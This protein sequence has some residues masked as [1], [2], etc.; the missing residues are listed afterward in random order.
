MQFTDQNFEAEV[1]KSDVPVL[2]DFFAEWC[3]PCLMMGPII[4]ELAEEMKDKKV[5]IGKV[6]ID[7]AP[8]AAKK[9]N[10]MS[11]PTIIIFKD[12]EPAETMSG[13]QNKET[14]REKLGK[15]I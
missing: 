9:Y 8:E 1:I 13:I 3:G 6:N 2:V 10:V 7:E 4:E 12:G 11:I 14:L 15:L 5:K